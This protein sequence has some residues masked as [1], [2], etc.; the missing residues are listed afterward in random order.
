MCIKIFRIRLL[1]GCAG[2]GLNVTYTSSRRNLEMI[3][4]LI[5]SGKILLYL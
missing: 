2:L 3:I 1:F 4:I 5:G